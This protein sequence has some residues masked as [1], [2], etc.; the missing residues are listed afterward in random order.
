V[1]PENV[2]IHPAAVREARKAYR[3]YLRHSAVAASRFQAA[4]EAGIEQIVEWPEM[5]PA[6]LHGTR[7]YLLRRFPYILVYRKLDEVVQ[8]VAV[9]HGSR[10]PGY[11]RR[12]KFRDN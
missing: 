6:Y 8:I 11:W 12:R 9:A 3:W 10:R 2:E 7:F 1:I 4:F 5:W